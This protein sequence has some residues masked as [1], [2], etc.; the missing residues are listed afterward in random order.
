MGG[1]RNREE[2]HT[3]RSGVSGRLYIVGVQLHSF[4]AAGLAKLRIQQAAAHVPPLTPIIE[5]CTAISSDP[6][7]I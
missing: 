4:P 1:E 2:W 7:P 6:N 5:A 3:R